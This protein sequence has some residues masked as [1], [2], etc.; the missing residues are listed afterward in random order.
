MTNKKKNEREQ[1]N[2]RDLQSKVLIS[3]GKISS[4]VDIYY[5][6]I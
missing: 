6:A 5:D 2:K 3:Y 4:F 1:T